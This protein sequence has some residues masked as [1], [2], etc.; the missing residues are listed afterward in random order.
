MCVSLKYQSNLNEPHENSS[1]KGNQ[2][3]PLDTVSYMYMSL[4]FIYSNLYRDMGWEW[5]ERDN[6]TLRSI[7]NPIIHD[8]LFSTPAQ[9][10]QHVKN[11]RNGNK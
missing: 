3:Q 8:D 2:D 11:F 4:Q 5:N 1:N 9:K 10:S 7:S 6:L